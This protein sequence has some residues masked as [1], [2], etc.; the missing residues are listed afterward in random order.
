[1]HRKKEEG[2]Y[3]NDASTSQAMSGTDNGPRSEDKYGTDSLS[4]PPEETNPL[5]PKFWASGLQNRG[6]INSF[7]FK[8][9]SPWCVI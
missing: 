2:R 8:P 9:P 1:M 4:G 5:T 3:W 6:K 7:R